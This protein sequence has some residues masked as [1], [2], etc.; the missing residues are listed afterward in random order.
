MSAED[1]CLTGQGRFPLNKEAIRKQLK[2]KVNRVLSKSEWRLFKT[3]VV[4]EMYTAKEGF[5]LVQEGASTANKQE[6]L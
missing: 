4:E 3:M 5:D 6:R 1:N 2:N